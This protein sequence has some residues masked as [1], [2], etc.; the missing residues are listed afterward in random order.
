MPRPSTVSGHVA[1]TLVNAGL[2]TTSLL[3]IIVVAD[4]IIIA[5]HHYYYHYY[6]IHILLFW[7]Q[8]VRRE[9]VQHV[10]SSAYLGAIAGGGCVS[11]QTPWPKAV[12][13]IIHTLFWWPLSC[14]LF[15]PLAAIG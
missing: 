6:D 7:F 8:S 11:W 12:F 3:T 13:A 4:V 9:T 10:A 14:P 1:A 2:A 15:T 5:I